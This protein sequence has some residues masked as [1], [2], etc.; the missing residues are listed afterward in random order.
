MSTAFGIDLLYSSKQ[1]SIIQIINV[2]C[3]KE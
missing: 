1:K 2:N 3:K